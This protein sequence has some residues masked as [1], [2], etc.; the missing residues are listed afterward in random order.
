METKFH[1]KEGDAYLYTIDN[2][3]APEYADYLFN[4][5]DKLPLIHNPPNRMGISHRDVGFYSNTVPYYKFAGQK[6]RS[7]KTP[8]FLNSLL[9]VINKTFEA[10][11]SQLAFKLNAILV[12]R[13]TSGE[14]NID[15][16]SDSEKQLK[17]QLILALSLFKEKD[18]NRIFRIR[19]KDKG[20]IDGKNYMDIATKHVQLLVMGG[21]FQELFTHEVPVEKRNKKAYRISYTIRSHSENEKDYD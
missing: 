12:N 11:L 2:F 3:V 6:A 10:S 20:K 21:N 1:I 16:H 15:K 7:T 8:E 9:D 13:Y 18:G 14:D 4:E 17:Q 19:R 5:G